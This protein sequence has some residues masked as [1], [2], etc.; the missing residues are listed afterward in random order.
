[1]SKNKMKFETYRI[2]QNHLFEN[3][4]DKKIL[5]QLKKGGSDE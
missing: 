5:K 3:D 2:V 1:M 4:Y